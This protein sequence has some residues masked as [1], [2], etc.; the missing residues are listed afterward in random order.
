MKYELIRTRRK[1]IAICIRG[2]LVTVRAPLRAP[3][4]EIDRFVLS[5]TAWIEK[6]TAAWQASKE[7]RMP[8]PPGWDDPARR[9][10]LIASYKKQAL[11]IFTGRTAYFAPLLCVTPAGIKIGSA[12]SR[13]GSCNSAGLITFSWRL[14]LASQ[15]AIDYVVVHEL[16]HLKQ[17]N[18]S[19]AFWAIVAQIL[20]HWKERRKELRLLHQRLSNED[21]I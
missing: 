19:P 13:W 7:Q 10:K 8:P 17:M 14:M 15:D 21:W 18:H 11:K 2:G 4:R 1:T 12:K 20:P 9:R 16:A 5:K 6:H 3:L